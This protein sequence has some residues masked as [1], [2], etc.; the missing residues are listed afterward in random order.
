MI[1]RGL[2]G[3]FKDEHPNHFVGPSSSFVNMVPLYLVT[4]MFACHAKRALDLGLGTGF[5]GP[6]AND[7]WRSTFWG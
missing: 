1:R 6:E 2:G 3:W 7:I 5:L 4:V